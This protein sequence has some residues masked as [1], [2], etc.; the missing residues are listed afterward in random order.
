MKYA[1]TQSIVPGPAALS[2]REKRWG[3][4]KTEKGKGDESEP[5]LGR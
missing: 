2:W 5:T 4:K 3:R 1:R